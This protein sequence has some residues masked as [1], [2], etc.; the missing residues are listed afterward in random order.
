VPSHLKITL[1]CSLAASVGFSQ[2]YDA[3]K[4]FSSAQN[5]NGV[6]SYGTIPFTGGQFTGGQFTPLPTK[7]IC[8][9]LAGWNYAG[10]GGVPPFI[11]GGAGTCGGG[12]APVGVLDMHPSQN[13]DYAVVRWTSPADGTYTI[14]G[15]F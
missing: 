7:S 9:Q 11:Y 2:T 3:V 12:M 5:S 8:G 10:T 1:F 4:D 14:S 6:W 13:G 15:A